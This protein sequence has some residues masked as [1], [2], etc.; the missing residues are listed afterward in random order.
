MDEQPVQLLKETRHPIREVMRRREELF[1]PGASPDTP[2]VVMTLSQTGEIR[3]RAAG[4]GKSPPEWLP[5]Y[6]DESPSDWY[7]ARAGDVV[8]SSIDLWKW[9]IAVVPKE[10]DGAL[11][12]KEFPI[13]EVID[14]RVDPQFLSHLLRSRYCQRA[15]RAITTGHS[16]RRRTQQS[17]FEELEIAFPADK[18]AQRQLIQPLVS[19]TATRRAAHSQ[20]VVAAREFD[21]I[22]DG[23]NPPDLPELEAAEES[24]PDE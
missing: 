3:P 24:D 2:V 16:N 21:S 1:L 14:K 15:F 20:T 10:F 17:D 12:T 11:V 6:L 22:I 8:Y 18:A 7:R 23:R 13:Y 4:K 5:I 9:C 19:A